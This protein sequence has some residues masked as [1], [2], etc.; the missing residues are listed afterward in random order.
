VTPSRIEVHHT[1]KTARG[2][3][4]LALEAKRLTEGTKC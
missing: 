2:R 3:T 1:R 4:R